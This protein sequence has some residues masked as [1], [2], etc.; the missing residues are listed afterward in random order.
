[1]MSIREHGRTPVWGCVLIGG[2]SSRMGTP[3]HLLE[4]AGRTWI[5]RT[6]AVLRGR[7]E[8]VVIAGAGALPAALAEMI[9]VDDE[10]GRASSRERV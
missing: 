9:R 6:V 3:K 1:M 4:T 7:V 10:I 8:Q 5:E 2:K